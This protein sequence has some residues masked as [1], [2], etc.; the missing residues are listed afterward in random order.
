MKQISSQYR[1][2][3]TGLLLNN[4]VRGQWL[5]VCL[6]LYLPYHITLVHTHNLSHTHTYTYKQVHTHTYVAI[7]TL[8]HAYIHKHTQAH[9]LL[10]M[11]SSD[12]SFVGVLSTTVGRL[13]SRATN[14][15]NGAE[16][17]I[18]GNYFH[19]WHWRCAPPLFTIHVN[20]RATRLAMLED[21]MADKFAEEKFCSSNISYLRDCLVLQQ[22]QL[23]A[24]RLSDRAYRS[25]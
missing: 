24:S 22:S 21:I 8:T 14:F 18:R 5:Y 13:F 12:N 15:V 9:T 4:H 11:G 23:R 2:I 1:I 16:E 20:L 10:K 17:R 3:F 7:N 19:K 6:H 25:W